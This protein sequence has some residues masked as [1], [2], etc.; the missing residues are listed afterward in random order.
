MAQAL[1]SE[2]VE[3]VASTQSSET[4]PISELSSCPS[5]P[6]EV[7]NGDELVHQSIELVLEDPNCQVAQPTQ[8][9]KQTSKQPLQN[10]TPTQQKTTLIKQI[11]SRYVHFGPALKYSYVASFLHTN[12]S[13]SLMIDD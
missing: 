3:V 4:E 7:H 8:L 13:Y 2:V 12:Y 11:Q 1:S 10:R 6:P 5:G 9:S